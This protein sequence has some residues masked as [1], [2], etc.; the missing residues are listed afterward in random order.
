MDN[1]ISAILT[2]L[3]RR[4]ESLYG[5]RLV[6]ML[7]YG[8]RARGD[9]DTGSDIDVLVVLKAPVEPCEEIARTIDDVSELSLEH[10]RSIACVFVSDEEFE[11]ERSPLLLNVRRE[12]IAV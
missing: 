2:E 6:G 5:Q 12:G 10:D 1:Q 3:R 9:A 11:R 7:L 8:S 4:M